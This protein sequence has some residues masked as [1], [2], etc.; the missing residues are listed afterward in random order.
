[1]KPNP[2]SKLA[3]ATVALFAAA[4]LSGCM[5]WGGSDQ[6]GPGAENQPPEAAIAVD[7]QSGFTGESFRFDATGSDDPD[8]NITRYHFDFGDGTSQDVEG[9]Q[10]P[11]VEHRY[12][13]GGEYVATV[14][15]MDNGAEHAGK[16]ADT[17]ETQV[18]VNERMPIQAAVITAS[19]LNQ[20][21][22]DQMNYTFEV[23]EGVDRFELEALIESVLVAGSSQVRIRVL[24][25]DGNVVEEATE[26]VNAGQNETVNLED[27]LT[28]TGEYTIE[29][30][31]ES[32]AT[33]VSGEN[34]VFYG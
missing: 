18:N 24:D 3:L 34:R 8:G 6:P 13:D 29:F 15:V 7:K 27:D 25:P 16:E 2:P 9:T 4:S 26:T 10:D 19:P 31:A 5:G 20:S 14:V 28:E 23:T 22:P 1:M 33:R 11:K 32:G 17:A 21:G 30:L 12:V